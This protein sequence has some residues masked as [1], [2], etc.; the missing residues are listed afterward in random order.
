VFHEK[1]RAPMYSKQLYPL[2][3]KLSCKRELEK[4][5][6]AIDYIILSIVLYGTFNLAIVQS[7]K[8]HHTICCN[9]GIDFKSR[10][11]KSEINY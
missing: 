7:N 4:Y 6:F 10:I 2:L 1:P 3:L 11:S 9:I 8:N 5:E